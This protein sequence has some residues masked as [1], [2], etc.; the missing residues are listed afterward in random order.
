VNRTID[1][2]PF[3]NSPVGASPNG[4]AISNDGRFLFVANAT[5]ND[6]AII[7]LGRGPIPDHSDGLIPVG[8]VPTGVA[9]APDNSQLIVVN[10]KGLGA[11]PNLQGP[12]PYL[13]PESADN[14]YSGSMIVGSL[15][16]IDMADI[17]NQFARNTSQ[18]FQNDRF[19]G[20]IRGS[21]DEVIKLGTGI[22]GPGG[23]AAAAAG[24]QARTITHS[25]GNTTELGNA[26]LRG[27]LPAL[28]PPVLSVTPALT[29]GNP[30]PVAGGG[31]ASVG[32]ERP[33]IDVG[34]RV[35]DQPPD[36]LTNELRPSSDWTAM[37][38]K[39]FGL[40][41]SQASTTKEL[42]PAGFVF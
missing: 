36:G 6:V 21:Q 10:S 12:N 28:S 15:S 5:D 18:V 31:L 39:A 3:P 11:G 20:L 9:L 37:V 33:H 2:K 25:F 1:L 24:L 40:T 35:A 13:D 23:A 7:Q 16:L 32:A 27:T 4:L 34:A 14:Q 38:D 41:E 19:F 26:L 30:S 42:G 8:W 17:A 22:S 29:V